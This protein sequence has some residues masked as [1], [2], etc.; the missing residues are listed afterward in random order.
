MKI[1]GQNVIETIYNNANWSDELKV[2]KLDSLFQ[3]Y[4]KDGSL[5]QLSEHSYKHAKWLYNSGRIEKAIQ[6]LSEGIRYHS[7]DTL[8]LQK[9]YNRLR[10]YLENITT[11]FRFYLTYL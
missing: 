2:Q 7:S 1:T 5:D 6:V 8:T 11:M 10:L 9:K 3:G 4:K